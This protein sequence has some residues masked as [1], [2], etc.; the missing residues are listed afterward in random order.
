MAPATIDRFKKLLPP[1]LLALVAAGGFF[2][3]T[4]LPSWLASADPMRKVDVIVVPAGDPNVRIPRAIRFLERYAREVWVVPSGGGAVVNEA[5]AIEAYA[6]EHGQAGSVRVLQ[7]RSRTLVRDARI[8]AAR[9]KRQEREKRTDLEIAVVTSPLEIA[10]T[11]LVFERETGD[12]VLAWRAGPGGRDGSRPDSGAWIDLAGETARVL[13]TLAV[14]GPGTELLPGNVPA[15]LPLRGVVG[16]LLVALAV[17]ALCRP[18]ARRLG[19]VATPRLWRAHTTPTP[20]LGGLAIILGLG[21][22]IVAAGG[23]RLGALGAA[24]AAGVV[25]VAVVG[26]IDDIAGL[27]TRVRLLWAGGAGAV[28]WLLGLRAQ[29]IAPG[30]AGADVVNAIFTILWFVGIT[31]ALNIFDNVDGAVGGVAAISAGTIAIAAALGGQFVVTVAAAALCGAC[32]GYLAHNVH[33]ARLFMGDMGALGLGFALA[34]LG[35]A[36]QPEQRPPLSVAVPVIAVGVPIFDTV[37]VTIARI[38]A[39]GSPFVGGTDHASHR[40]LARGLS[41]RQA[42]GFLWASQ[43][44]L[45]ALAVAIARSSSAV[46]G[47]FLTGAVIASGIVALIVFFRISPWRPP[48]QMQASAQ[49]VEAVDRAMRALRHLEETVGDEAWR[50]SNPRAARST[51]ETLK[52]LERVHDLLDRAPAPTDG[53]AAPT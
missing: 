31:H 27:G 39:G 50:L 38:R 30:E 25:V 33:P 52:R 46:V 2:I 15:S 32:L 14:L 1:L 26:L 9:L 16:G 40:L 29:V 20:M 17:G 21:G 18:L 12:D 49:V 28:A 3:W 44:A 5:K 24:A 36:L 23:V 48:W 13:G 47:G 10:R 51:Q 22:G 45:G 34:A 37:L 35:L 8:V 43:I 42:A 7:R 19:L 11:R 53:P 6:A 41:V 4:H